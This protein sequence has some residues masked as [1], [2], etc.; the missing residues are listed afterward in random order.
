MNQASIK[1]LLTVVWLACAIVYGTQHIGLLHEGRS[2]VVPAAPI[3]AEMRQA[4]APV[5]AVVRQADRAKAKQLAAAWRD[6][7]SML[8]AK[9]KTTGQ[10]KAAMQAFDDAAFAKIGL[11]GAVP[12]F[13]DAVEQAFVAALGKEDVAVDAAKSVEFFNA[14]AAACEV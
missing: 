11:T 12:G 1:Q 8:P 10:L 6:F 9:I 7:A 4:V 5:Q 3:S 2:P 13:G 14:L